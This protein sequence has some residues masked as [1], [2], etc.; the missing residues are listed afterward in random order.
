MPGDVND[1]TLHGADGKSFAVVEQRIEF[2]ARAG[3][4]EAEVEYFAET[5]LHLDDLRSDADLAAELGLEIRRGRKMLG[6]HMRLQVPGHLEIAR[7][8]ELDELFGSFAAGAAGFRVEIEHRIDDR[9]LR[10][11]S[12]M[13]DMAQRRG[14]LI[15]EAVDMG[16]VRHR[17]DSSPGN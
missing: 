10:A 13:D 1:R 3:N 6:V 2:G 9:R 12:R 15:E 16:R 17:R 8:H 5:F 4:V 11:R 14:G 7:P